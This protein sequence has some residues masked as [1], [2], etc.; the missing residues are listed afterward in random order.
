MGGGNGSKWKYARKI[1]AGLCNSFRVERGSIGG[2]CFSNLFI[3]AV[4]GALS[5][6]MHDFLKFIDA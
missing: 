5:F 1:P 3:E 6:K 4:G 2:H